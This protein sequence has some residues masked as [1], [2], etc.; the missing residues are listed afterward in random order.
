MSYRSDVCLWLSREAVKKMDK[1]MKEA[2]ETAFCKPVRTRPSEDGKVWHCPYTGWNQ[3]VDED[4][5]VGFLE[6]LDRTEGELYE[7]IV[8]GEGEDDW[9][10]R[11]NREY[12]SEFHLSSEVVFYF[13]GERLK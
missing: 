2:F 10:E 1:R 6:S 5:I 12:A 4:G 13:D 11:T 7:L 8:I 3:E 9:Q